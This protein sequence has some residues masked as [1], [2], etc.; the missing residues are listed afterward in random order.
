MHST[1]AHL[2]A[3]LCLLSFL[4]LPRASDADIGWPSLRGPSYDGARHNVELFADPDSTLQV[5]WKRPLGSGYSAVVIGEGHA[6][7]LFAAGEH[8]VVAAFDVETGDERWRTTIGPTY[9]G[10]DGSHDGPIS[11]PLLA[12]GKIFT[13]GGW[14]RLLAL[15]AATGETRWSTHLNEDLGAKKPFYGFAT[16]PVLAAGVLVVQV[17]GGDGNSIVG[18]DPDDGTVRWSFGDDPVV[19]QSPIVATIAGREQVLA[20]TAQHLYGIAAGTGEVLWQHEHG[21]DERGMGGETIIPVPAGD[22][23]V[24]LLHKMDE[25]VMVQV[26]QQGS[27][28]AVETLWANNSIR[29][30]YVHPV[31][32]EGFLYGMAGRILTCVDAATGERRWRSREPGDGF[33][34]LVGDQLV[35]ITKPGTLHVA[36]ATPEGYRERAQLPLFNEHSWSAVAYADGHLYAR[37]MAQLARIDTTAVA[38]TSE[39]DDSWL[40]S[41][42]FGR[43]LDQ[44]AIDDDKAASVDA[45]LEAQARFPIVEPS[46][47]V[48][49]L[50]R[51]P[52]ED[53][54]IV[55]DMIGYRREDPMQR[56]PGTDLFYYSTRL[57]PTAAV[58][59]GFI[60]SYEQTTPDPRNP[61]TG[62]S[63]FG[64]VSW[65]AMPAWPGADFTVAGQP[66]GRLETVRWTSAI[67][68]GQEREVS[69]YLPM[70]YNRDTERRYPVLY[71]HG[72]A[73][74]LEHGAYQAS[75]DNLIGETVEPLIAVFVVGEHRRWDRNN[76][77]LYAQ[78]IAEEL[79]PKIDSVYRTRTDRMARA[80]A[81]TAD[82]A[83]AALRTAFEHPEV[84]GRV[85]IQS[86]TIMTA[87]DVA[88]WIDAADL[89]SMVIYHDWGTYHLRSPHEAWDMAEANRELF[90]VFRNRGY[91]PAGGETPDGF[92][93]ACWRSRTDDLLKALFPRQL[94]SLS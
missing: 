73:D 33:P 81:G 90:T 23:R 86:P 47:A 69:V 70:G 61:Q 22:D 80:S 72:G 75:L 4:S 19:Y 30:T 49:F 78:M 94:A 39:T 8:D 41:T 43:F 13:L 84:F 44:V 74:A 77:P 24:L 32:H 37:S 34:T 68:E 60:P 31:Y 79:V 5:G 40:A 21:G 46:G 88:P 64:T 1:H 14:G 85:A 9:G 6:F 15:D 52:D 83:S 62:R 25:S 12:D 10:H 93:W 54:G 29:G 26:V 7:T 28:F 38:G 92:G 56:V 51:G 87:D 16:S 48:H 20:A 17:G 65:F 59:Y 27:G 66:K 18:F 58:Y 11:T 55:G 89:R 63:L 91:R 57:E 67:G 3:T 42:R 45:F 76:Q 71:V 36:E 50:Y 2:V 35:I 82:A 53:V